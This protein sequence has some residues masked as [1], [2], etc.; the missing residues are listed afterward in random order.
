M[1]K[2]KISEGSY[3]K[4]K[5]RIIKEISYDKLNMVNQRSESLFYDVRTS[6]EDF[7]N[8]LKDAVYESKYGDYGDGSINPYL[9]EIIQYCE[10]IEDILYA[11]K[12]QQ[13]KFKAELDKIDDENSFADEYNDND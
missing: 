3:N 7:Y 10:K 11:K 4:L 12:A 9:Q 8:A 6:F 13:D 5:D 1:K 2:V